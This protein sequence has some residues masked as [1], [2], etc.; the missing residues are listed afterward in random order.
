MNCRRASRSG[1]N[2]HVEPLKL[3]GLTP[4]RAE[5][6]NDSLRKIVPI[7]PIPRPERPQ[8]TVPI[9]QKG[10]EDAPVKGILLGP[11]GWVDLLIIADADA[12]PGTLRIPVKRQIGFKVATEVVELTVE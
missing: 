12:Q 5:A 2:K 6:H 3:I 4:E 8:L 1:H 11:D 7:E 10:P 9:L